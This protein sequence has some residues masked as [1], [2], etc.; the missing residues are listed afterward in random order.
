M[1][2][3][4]VNSQWLSLEHSVDDD[5]R[6]RSTKVKLK[7]KEMQGYFFFVYMN[8]RKKSMNTRVACIA[9]K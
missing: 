3:Q 1:L 4:V 9:N 5:R 2:P 8:I 6:K 7:A